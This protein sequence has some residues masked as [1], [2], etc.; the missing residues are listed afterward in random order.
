MRGAMRRPGIISLLIALFLW[1]AP[2]PAAFA[3]DADEGSVD[4]AH[5]LFS[6]IGDSYGWHITDWNGRH[7]SIPLPC[8]V[9][10]SGGWHVFMSAEIGHGHV[11]EG[12]FVA[13]EGPYEGKIVSDTILMIQG[14]SLLSTS[15]VAIALASP[16]P[17][18][19]SP[20]R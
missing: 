20:L 8:I 7:V 1:C 18:P 3:E 15:A 13:E 14:C 17:L 4:V 2:M 19:P 9:R 6:H 5:L 11:Y 12:F 10:G 16:F